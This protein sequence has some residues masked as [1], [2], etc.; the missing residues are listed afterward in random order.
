MRKWPSPFHDDRRGT[1]IISGA[2]IMNVVETFGKDLSEIEI[3]FSGAGAS[4]IATAKS[5]LSLGAR[6]PLSR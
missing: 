1:A 4:A 5:Y 3:V 6:R 2:A